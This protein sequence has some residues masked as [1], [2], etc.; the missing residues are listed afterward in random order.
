MIHFANF[1][2]KNLKK[3]PELQDYLPFSRIE[4]KEAYLI[5][6]ERDMINGKE[7]FTL[8]ALNK[9]S[10]VKEVLSTH[11]TS[12]S[13]FPTFNAFEWLQDKLPLTLKQLPTVYPRR[14]YPAPLQLQ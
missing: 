10:T 11:G 5:N 1:G 7:I 9:T 4:V 6:Y 2:S 14:I 13:S 3:L 8:T 12:K